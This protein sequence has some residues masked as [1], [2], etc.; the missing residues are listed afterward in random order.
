MADQPAIDAA[1]RVTGRLVFAQDVRPAGVLETAIVRSP[2]AHARVTRVDTARAT[3]VPGVVVAVGGA[4]LESEFGRPITFGPVYR[5][6]PALAV[7]TVRYVGE[8]VAAI[9]AADPDVAR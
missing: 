6:Q 8:P 3:R 9:V 1:D 7:D 2:H 4:E 5:D